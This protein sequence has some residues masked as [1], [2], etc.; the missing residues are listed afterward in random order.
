MIL[1]AIAVAFG[2]GVSK[3][4]RLAVVAALIAAY[5][6][7]ARLLA[8]AHRLVASSEE[9]ATVPPGADPSLA[10][11][12]WGEYMWAGSR[13]ITFGMLAAKLLLYA[14]PLAV[15]AAAVMELRGSDP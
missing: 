3:S 7:I 4:A 11:L 5:T 12:G 14:G 8:G 9:T 13:E 1:A 2:A 6:A 15:A 10:S